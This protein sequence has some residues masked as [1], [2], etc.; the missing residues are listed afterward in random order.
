MMKRRDFLKTTSAAVIGCA[1][2]PGNALAAFVGHPPCM[3]KNLLR[4]CGSQAGSPYDEEALLAFY[5]STIRS[6]KSFWRASYGK[7]AA[8]VILQDMRDEF[9]A[10]IP[11]I[12]YIGREF[13]EILIRTYIALAKYTVLKQ[14]GTPLAENAQLQYQAGVTALYKMPWL[15]RALVGRQ[16]F[17]EESLEAQ[18]HYAAE[19]QKREYPENWVMEFVEGDGEEFDFGLDITECPAVKCFPDH[20]AGEFT[21]CICPF[22]DITSDAFGYGLKRTTTLAWGGDVCDFRYKQELPRRRP[23][24]DYSHEGVWHVKVLP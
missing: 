7:A 1:L 15:A 19:T 17:S 9:T 4:R 5:D 12:P 16:F 23:R 20:D 21:A 14:H 24:D 22:D 6:E 10:L 2:A 13:P 3:Q 11:A 18:R 8:D